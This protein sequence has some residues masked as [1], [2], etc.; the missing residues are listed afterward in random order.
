MLQCHWQPGLQARVTVAWPIWP[1]PWL[2]SFRSLPPGPAAA[3]G[4]PRLAGPRRRTPSPVTWTHWQTSAI[5]TTAIN[6]AILDNKKFIVTYYNG[7]QYV[8][9]VKYLTIFM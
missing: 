4:G 3:R 2:M 5:W 1:R 6:I 8:Q 9:Y 7:K